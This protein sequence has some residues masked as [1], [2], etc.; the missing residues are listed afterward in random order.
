MLPL[1]AGDKEELVKRIAP[2]QS[3]M[4]A[5]DAMRFVRLREC[6]QWFVNRRFTSLGG[7]T[8]KNT[9]G[10]FDLGRHGRMFSFMYGS[11]FAPGLSS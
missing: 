7:E 8:S 1:A 9:L 5:D 6:C 2:P 11:M 3:E 10:Y 4:E